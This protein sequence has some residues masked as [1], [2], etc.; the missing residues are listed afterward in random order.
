VELVS[1]M[2]LKG[3]DCTEISA[4]TGLQYEVVKKI[5]NNETVKQEVRSIHKGIAE[6]TYEDKVPLLKEIVDL[7]LNAVKDKLLQLRDPEV[8][9]L[10]IKD[11]RD[12]AAI[13]KLATDLNSLLRLELGKST[14]NIETVSHNY[15]ETKI[16]L[17]QLKNKDPVFDY[18]ELPDVK[19]ESN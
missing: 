15:Q 17:Q 3:M 6:R 8:A 14:H 9:T 12:L 7:S 2:R 11:A 5:C 4:A 13:G 18:P 10:M 16:I 19:T 1:E